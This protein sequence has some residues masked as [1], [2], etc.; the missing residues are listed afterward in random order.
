MSPEII[1]NIIEDEYVL[2]FT[3][4]L[5][6]FLHFWPFLGRFWYFRGFGGNFGFFGVVMSYEIIWWIILGAGRVTEGVW[7]V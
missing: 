5:S 4:T 1:V 7:G 3:F 6:G 2:I